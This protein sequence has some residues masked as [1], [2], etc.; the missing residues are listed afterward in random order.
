MRLFSGRS[1]HSSVLSAGLIIPVLLTIAAPLPA[2]TFTVIHSFTGAIDGASPYSG[3]TID[4]GGN[5]YGSTNAGNLG[6]GTV[7]RLRY[8]NSAWI[9]QTLYAFQGSSHGNDGAHPTARIM[10]HNGIPY[11][12]TQAGGLAGCANNGGCGTIFYLQPPLAVCHTSLCPWKETVLYRFG[13][14]ADGG[15]PVGDLLVDS[16]GNVF[17][18]TSGGGNSGCNY[19][20]GNACGVVYKLTSRGVESV[21]YQMPGGS[22]G[23][24]PESGVA[25]DSSGNLLGTTS[26]GG[27]ASL[28][29][30]FELTPSQGGWSESSLYQFQSGAGGK[31]PWA[32][33]T[34]D[35]AGNFYGATTSGGASGGGTIFQLTPSG[36]AWNYTP[37]Y[38]FS[39][40]ASGP[41][42]NLTIDSSGSLY[43]TIPSGG[44]FGHGSV[45]KLIRVNGSW[46]Y[47]SLHDFSG[48][49][50][51]AQPA[52]SVVVDANGNVYGTALAGG[53]SNCTGGCGVVW[54]VSQ[55]LTITTSSLPSGITGQPYQAQLAA[56]GGQPP[57][58]WTLIGGSLPNGLSLNSGGAIS[59]TPTAPGTFPFTVQVTD[60]AGSRASKSLSI[61]VSS[62]G[63]LTITTTQLP[64]AEQSVPY[65]ATLSAAGGTPPYTWSLVSGALPAGL[66]LNTNG[67]IQGTPSTPG[68]SIFTV[69][70]KDSLSNIAQASLQIWVASNVGNTA[71]SGEY[72][73]LLNGYSGGSPYYMV[74][75]VAADGN[76]NITSGK[77]DVNYG[78]GEPSD[79]SH[80]LGNRFCPMPET[81]QS[82]G[83]TYDLSANDGLGSMTLATVDYFGNPHTYRFS[84]SVSGSACRPSPLL[85]DCGRVIQRDPSNP[86]IYGSGALMVQDPQYLSIDAFFPGN[87]S[88]LAY[89]E[90]PNG[91]RFAAVGALGTNPR[92][93]ID[94]DC[95]GN[96]WGFVHCPLDANDN[97]SVISDPFQGTLASTLDAA[98][99]RGNFAII[100]F[101]NDPNG[102]CT[103]GS[104]PACGY[105]YYIVNRQEMVFVSG[106]ALSKPG[107]PS[108]WLFHRQIPG[109][110]WGNSALSGTTVAEL[111]GA[112]SGGGVQAS[113]GL[114]NADGAGHAMFTSDTNN[115]GTF[116]RQSSSGTYS[117]DTVGARSGRA[118]L[119]GFSQ[120][121][122]GSEL[123]LYDSNAGYF[124][125][126]DT[127]V[128]F[129]IFDP[130]SGAPFSNASVSG[131]PVG[132]TMWPAAAG[133]TNSVTT[134]FANGAGA[135]AATQNTSGPSGVGGPNNL[136]LTYQVD[137]TGRA[138]VLQNGSQFG[139]LYVVGPDKFVLLPNGSAPAL[140]VFFAGQPD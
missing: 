91:K 138:V 61:T 118:T 38:S 15:N 136:S 76:G 89:G 94:I 108:I 59:G 107:I 78:Q 117:F 41:V 53:S 4:Q 63:G 70:V 31:V 126:G 50:D 92:T 17:G 14:H 102:T 84:I 67:T 48:G 120:F 77:L 65:S 110:A 81:V 29:T 2:Q 46:T 1:L 57:Y 24:Y 44:A 27:A 101:P 3:L 30:I 33:L 56:S 11:G 129:G 42:S 115:A 7:F 98:T 40:G 82:P 95:N 23:T 135:I 34:P 137:S 125:G 72:L 133:V 99:G 112:S 55:G 111:T 37:I 54:M 85:S 74:A 103:G 51:G 127:N 79:P 25:F 12:A 130:Q 9:L 106:D 97:G 10:L 26:Q 128:T 96:G 22:G 5:F 6:N 122:A 43:G 121:G 100:G 80:C 75:S 73:I 104:N 113:A 64:N 134:L 132:S 87:F 49:S 62:S 71:L 19:Q 18:S 35:G 139:I 60:S 47:T 119:S 58:T 20:P 69:Q 45:F 116:T 66:N 105:V 83:S 21:L 93:L 36:G 8:R 86:Q 140:N 68:L 114:F 32:G 16:S 52:G 131:N 39:A 13:G 123:W 109:G 28:G 124:L 90:D 88:F